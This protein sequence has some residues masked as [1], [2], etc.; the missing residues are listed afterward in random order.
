MVLEIESLQILIFLKQILYP[1]ERG[2]Y[3]FFLI[4]EKNY[5]LK[6]PLKLVLTSTRD[7]LI[8]TL[9]LFLRNLLSM[10]DNSIQPARG[11]PAPYP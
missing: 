11:T 10:L 5:N 1:K 4:D 3:L 7:I 6:E 2:I 8:P 9:A